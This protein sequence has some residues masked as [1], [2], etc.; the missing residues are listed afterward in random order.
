ME[1]QLLTKTKEIISLSVV[2]VD[3]IRISQVII[4]NSSEA[5]QEI[6]RKEAK[7][8]Q[9]IFVFT[10]KGNLGRIKISDLGTQTL[11]NKGQNLVNLS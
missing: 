7:S 1:R 4:C 6:F 11:K 9:D 2:S 5:N 10:N 8:N 3:K